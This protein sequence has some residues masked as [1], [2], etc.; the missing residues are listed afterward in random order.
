MTDFFITVFRQALPFKG[1]PD[2][3]IFFASLASFA[4]QGFWGSLTFKK[5]QKLQN[6][7]ERPNL[8]P[9]NSMLDAKEISTGP[10]EPKKQGP[11]V[12]RT[13]WS[14]A[15]PTH[16]NKKSRI[17]PTALRELSCDIISNNSHL[18]GRGVPCRSF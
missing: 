15:G 17:E 7:P 6:E 9:L 4:R 3:L 18:R 14:A 13:P 1:N 10:K 5:N 16:Q 2:F 12:G 8:T 11:S